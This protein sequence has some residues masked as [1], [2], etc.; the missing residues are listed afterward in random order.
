MWEVVL[1]LLMSTE[2]ES[3][4]VVKRCEKVSLFLRKENV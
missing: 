4:Y 1:G 2:G 3:L